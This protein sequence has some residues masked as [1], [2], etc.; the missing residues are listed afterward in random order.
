ML[1]DKIKNYRVDSKRTDYS[2]LSKIMKDLGNPNDDIKVIHVAGNNGKG[3]VSK[4]I[5]AGLLFNDLRVGAINYHL[6]EELNEN[7]QFMGEK[8]DNEVLLKYYDDVLEV[9]SRYDDITQFDFITAL[10]FYIFKQERIDVCLVETDFDGIYDPVSVFIK[11]ILTVLTQI[12]I[13]SLG[14]LNDFIRDISISRDNS[15]IPLVFQKTSP[16]VEKVIV[17]KC[18]EFGIEH[19]SSASFAKEVVKESINGS[20]INVFKE[21][22]EICL[23][24]RMAGAHQQENLITAFLGLEVLRSKEILNISEDK[25]KKGFYSAKLVGRFEIVGKNPLYILDI[26][27]NIDSVN[28]LS[29]TIKKSFYKEDTLAIY[30]V[31]SFEN[32]TDTLK[33]LSNVTDFLIVVPTDETIDFEEL[34]DL[35]QREGIMGIAFEDLKQALSHAVKMDEKYKNIVIAG[36]PWIIREARKEILK[37]E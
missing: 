33:S 34:R 20:Q 30:G 23:G 24:T 3:C 36:N 21:G 29:T 11:P 8:I 19:I 1:I 26:A 9:T 12:G 10:S 25:C 6:L 4:F 28:A 17:S 37:W 5:G 32:I 22:K 27:N 18:D 2:N 14:Y 31:T 15:N 16:D 7:I 35:I 13:D